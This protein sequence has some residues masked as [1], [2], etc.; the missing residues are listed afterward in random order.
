MTHVHDHSH[1]PASPEAT[2]INAFLSVANLWGLNADEQITLLGS[3]LAVH[4]LQMEKGGR[5]HPD[6]TP[7]SGSLTS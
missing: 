7:R 4:L 2:E 6:A 1:Q 5:A 3:P